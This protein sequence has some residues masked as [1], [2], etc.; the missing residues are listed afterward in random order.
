MYVGFC[1][2]VILQQGFFGNQ[3]FL[4]ILIYLFILHISF[5]RNLDCHIKKTSP[6]ESHPLWH[7]NYFGGYFLV[8]VL[9][10]YTAILQVSP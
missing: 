2:K 4:N 1:S 9:R 6:T 8:E 5:D 10:S 3:D 7:K